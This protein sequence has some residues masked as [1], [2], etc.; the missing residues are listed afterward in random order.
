MTR[1][2]TARRPMPRAVPIALMAALVAIALMGVL[3]PSASA[4][5][6]EYAGGRSTC[7]FGPKCG[8]VGAAEAEGSK[9][10]IKAIATRAAIKAIGTARGIGR[11]AVGVRVMAVRSSDALVYRRLFNRRGTTIVIENETRRA[12]ERQRPRSFL[13]RRRSPTPGATGE[14]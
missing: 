14:E 5:P 12:Q 2:P 13:H 10:P 6:A 8:P 1:T 9:T 3:L 7:T 11:R 4:A